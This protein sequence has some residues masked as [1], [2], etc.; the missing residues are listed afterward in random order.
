MPV[1]CPK[2]GSRNLRFSRSR[3]ASER[4]G[5]WVGVRPLR[6]RDCRT[7]FV[8]RIWRFS[9]L[10]YAR[11]PKCWR[12]DLSRRG[13]KDFGAAPTYM[14]LAMKLGAYAYRCEYCRYNFLSLRPRRERFSFHRRSKAI[15]DDPG[16]GP[17]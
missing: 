13:E 6:C 3:S 11:C 14:A 4:M 7:R 9:D 16:S 17:A 10:A 15:K 1:S 2:C 5:K 12:M 8:D